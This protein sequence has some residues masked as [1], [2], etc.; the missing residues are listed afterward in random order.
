MKTPYTYKPLQFFLVTN[1]VMWAS[2]M[3]AAYLSY[4][5]GNSHDRMIS[6][7]ELIGLL[8]PAATAIWLVA[9]SG[10]RALKEDFISRLA[11]IRLIRLLSVPAILLL[12]PVVVV[13]SVVLSHVLFGQSM[14]QLRF[15]KGSPFPAGIVPA[16]LL[17]FLA[18]LVEETGWKGYGMDSLRGNRTFLSATLIF[19]ALWAA[20]HVPLFA[21]NNYYHNT[22]LRANPLYAVNFFVSLLAAAVIINWLWYTNGGSIIAAVAFHAIVNLQGILQMGQTA[23]CIETVI[24]VIIAVAIVAL[25]RN[26]FF[27]KFSP[28]TG[29]PG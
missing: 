25:N 6:A 13:L 11:D 2:W 5:P 27:S 3:A 12:T 10:N 23:K 17:I 22:I 15:V 16:Q 28:H 26:I 29:Y 7:L 14:E 8:S 20:W 24:F 18:P 1:I 19:G 4:I 9:A 21:V